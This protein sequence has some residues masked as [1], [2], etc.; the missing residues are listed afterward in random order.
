MRIYFLTFKR[1]GVSLRSTLRGMAILVGCG[2]NQGIVEHTLSSQVSHITR[3]IPSQFIWD[4]AFE[5][6]WLPSVCVY[7]GVGG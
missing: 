1:G 3:E 2:L 4:R 6:V 5:V 7:F